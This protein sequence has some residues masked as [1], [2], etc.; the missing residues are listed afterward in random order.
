MTELIQ[1]FSGLGAGNIGDEMMMHGFWRHLPPAIGLEVMLH[2]NSR[3]QHQPYP[4]RFRYRLM[5]LRPG[6][7]ELDGLKGR[8]GLLAGTTSVT[9][10]EGWQWPLAFLAPRLEHFHAQGLPVDAVGIGAD[11]LT[12]REGRTLFERHFRRV[13]SWSVR[14]EQ[15]RDALLEAGVEPARVVVGA[16]WAWLY[17]PP[18][19]D[20]RWAAE[21]LAGLG[22]RVGEPLLVVNLFWQG[23][24][25][26]FPI[27]VDVA[28]VLDRLHAED[29]LQIAFF[30][31][32]CRHPGFDRTA[33]EWVRAR[34]TAPAALIPNLYYGPGEA[35]ALLRHATV[36]LGQRYHF[37]VESV[38]AKTAPVML[39]RSPK[40]EG[41]CRE[42]GMAPLGTL[43]AIDPEEV[44]EAVRAAIRDRARLAASIEQT[45][46][47]LARR[48]LNNLAL[49]ARWYGRAESGL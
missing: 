42:F 30:C 16:D 28:R 38:A 10:A 33:A 4:E 40:I 11:R 43:T 48:A 2:E 3:A 22:I 23:H 12:T 18:A 41:L 45:R 49:F 26:S 1:I 36:T 20:G 39:G 34:M 29:G 17:E 21:L 13:R 37:F 31:N 46:Q 25:T 24:G 47:R 14:N 44:I 9:D 8:P 27:W 7:F 6:E 32:E 5:G 35:L 19:D 15:G